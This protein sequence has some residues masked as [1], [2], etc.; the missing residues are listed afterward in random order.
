MRD[1]NSRKDPKSSRWESNIVELEVEKRTMVT[2]QTGK[3]REEE[4]WIKGQTGG[5][6]EQGDHEYCPA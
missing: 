4:V 2:K 3:G 6:T 5:I 1:A